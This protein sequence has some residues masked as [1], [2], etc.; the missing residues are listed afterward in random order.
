MIGRAII[1]LC[2][3]L[4]AVLLIGGT[5]FLAGIG[6]EQF[7]YDMIHMTE[8]EKLIAYWW[9]WLLIGGGSWAVS[10]WYWR[11]EKIKRRKGRRR[12]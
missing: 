3:L 10:L 5:F 8:G 4:A 11:S 9:L 1:A 6:L 2:G 12:S 7:I